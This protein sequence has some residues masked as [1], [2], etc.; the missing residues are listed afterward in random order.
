MAL[1]Q[2]AVHRLDDRHVDVVSRAR[3]PA[4]SAWSTTPSATVSL[5]RQRFVERRAL[6][7]LDADRAVAAQRTGAREHEIAESG[8]PGERRRLRAQ[9]DAEPRHLGQPARDQ[10][11]ARVEAEPETLG[12]SRRDGHDVLERA[13]ELDADD[14]VVRVD[15]KVRR[16]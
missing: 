13:A 3:A 5:P 12:D 16:C 7:D 9:R 2:N 15:A 8:E 14:V 10:R 4:R 1:E 11:R 6:P